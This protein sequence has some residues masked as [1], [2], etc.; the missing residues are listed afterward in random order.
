[1]LPRAE[2]LRVR[3]GGELQLVR[4]RV[5]FDRLD[6]HRIPQR[7]RRGAR[8]QDDRDRDA[9]VEGLLPRRTPARGDGERDLLAL[10]RDR[11]DPAVLR[12][13]LGAE[14]AVIAPRVNAETA[15]GIEGF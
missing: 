15:E 4:A 12:P 5:R 11:V 1:D 8:A 3:R 13:V 14:A 9:G 10:R 6:D 7:T 2:G